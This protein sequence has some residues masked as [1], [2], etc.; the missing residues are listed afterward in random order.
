MAGLSLIHLTLLHI[1]GSTNP[2]GIDDTADY[3]S[4]YPYFLVKDFFGL[5]VFLL[6]FSYLVFFKPNMLGHPDNYIKANPLVTPAH[7]VPEWYFLPFYAIL[8]A[9]PDKLGGV[10]A[11]GGAIAILFLLPIIDRYDLLKQSAISYYL[12]ST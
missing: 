12:R 9:I 8:R 6:L 7:I 5:F 11:M 3:I 2:L 10:L 1:D 4:F